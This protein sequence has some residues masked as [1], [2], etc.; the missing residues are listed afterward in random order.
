V[1]VPG[2]LQNRSVLTAFEQDVQKPVA[3]I[4]WYQGWGVM[5][6]TQNF[7]PIWMNNVRNH[8]SIPM[9]SWEPWLYTAGVNQPAYSLQHI[10]NGGFDT[11]IKN[12]AK[13]SKAWGHPYFLRFAAE[14]NG[15]WF[16]WSEYEN[17]NRPDDY[18]KAWQHV[19]D[20]FTA[21]SVTNV[22]WVWSPNIEYAGSIPLQGLYPGSAYVDWIGMDGYNQGVVFGHSWRTFSQVFRPTYDAI[23]SLSHGKPLMIAE[24]ASAEQGGDKAAWITDAFATQMPQD[25]PAIQAVIWFNESKETDWRVESSPAAQ[26]AFAK[27][28]A[29]G[30]YAS[31]QF[32]H[33]FGSPIPV[34]SQAEC[35]F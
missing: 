29:L 26:A 12:W 4:M 11:Y 27:A 8:G 10:I 9:V 5:D 17:N 24:T 32:A 25:F 7:Q 35:S 30:V 2:S 14:M 19:H 18:V 34:A 13:D 20:I 3:I 28:I 23:L 6:G 1:H 16:P 33:L 21:N 22:T 31:N 15:T